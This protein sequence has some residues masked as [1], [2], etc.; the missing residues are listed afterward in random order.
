MD[1]SKFS[2]VSRTGLGTLLSKNATGNGRRVKGNALGDL[3]QLATAH[4]LKAAVPSSC[5]LFDE[6]P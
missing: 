3:L 1:L 2:S 4:G 6:P 5:N